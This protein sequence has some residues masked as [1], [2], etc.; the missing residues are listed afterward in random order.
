VVLREPCLRHR[1]CACMPPQATHVP[2]GTVMAFSGSGA[3]GKE[4]GAWFRSAGCRPVDYRSYTASR[5]RIWITMGSSRSSPLVAGLVGASRS[6]SA[7][8]GAQKSRAASG[9]RAM[10][11]T[12]WLLPWHL[13]AHRRSLL[14]SRWTVVHPQ[15][16]RTAVS[17]ASIT[18]YLS[19]QRAPSSA[20]G[21]PVPRPAGRRPLRHGLCCMKCLIVKASSHGA[22]SID[23]AAR[24]SREKELSLCS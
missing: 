15:E 2:S 20:R 22:G 18:T 16:P 21:A 4:A 12:P 8:K 10:V 7:D 14:P 11:W 1:P 17:L 24:S 9:G 23:G 6:G 3:T 5:W 13:T 19:S